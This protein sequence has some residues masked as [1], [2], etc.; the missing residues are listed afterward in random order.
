MSPVAGEAPDGPP[1]DNKMKV[2]LLAIPHV[3]NEAEENGPQDMDAFKTSPV[4]GEAPD[5]PP[6]ERRRRRAPWL[7]HMLKMRLKKTA[8]KTWKLLRRA[9][10]MVKH[11]TTHHKTRR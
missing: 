11:R 5:G 4:A 7:L 3:E 2:C 9:L 8:H 1:E 6:E 10:L